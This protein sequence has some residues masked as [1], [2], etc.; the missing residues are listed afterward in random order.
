MFFDFVA[1]QLHSS[2]SARAIIAHLMDTPAISSSDFILL[3]ILVLP[4]CPG[5]CCTS[6]THS[7][8]IRNT[9]IRI[10]RRRDARR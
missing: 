9:A 8:R 10:G 2:A 7:E 1:A 5:F 4:N 6:L 3:L